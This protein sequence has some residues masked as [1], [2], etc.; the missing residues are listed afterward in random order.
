MPN[1]I[2]LSDQNELIDASKFPYAQFPFDK[3]NPV[4]SRVFE[5]YDKDANALIAA[6]TS[7]GKTVVSEMF[8][9]YEVR[10]RGGKAMYL[11]PLKALTQEKID[12][13]TEECHH[14]S[15]LKL[16]ICTG[17][18]RL[19]PDRKQEL[20]DSD[21]I[22]M[23]TEMLNSVTRNYK[24]EKN[25][26]LS[27]VGT[28]VV[29]ESHLLTV[30]GRG[31]KLEVGLLKLTEINPDVRIVF[32]SAT[33]PNV[34]QIA[35]WLTRIN[36]KETYILESQ[37]RPCP[38]QIHY[39]AYDDSPWKYEAKEREKISVAIDLVTQH[40]QDKFL[41]FAHTKR[42]GDMMVKA[43]KEM[44][45]ESEFHNADLNKEKRKKLEHRFKTDKS[46]R[47][48]VSTS[49]LAWGVNVPAR[50]VI[51]LGVH[52]GMEIV[53]TYDISQMVGRAG[54]PK[55]DPRGDAYV[56]L[57][58]T[59][60]GEHIGRLTKPQPIISQ[61]VGDGSNFKVLAFH[62]ISEINHGSIKTREDIFAWY[63]RTLAAFQNTDLKHDLVDKMV[64][65]LKAC[66]AVKEEKG[67]FTTTPVG[68][69]AALFYFSPFDV[70]DFNR[71]FKAI[72]DN[73]KE[74]DEYWIAMALAN[75][76][77]HRGGIVSAAEKEQITE[78][79]NKIPL[80]VVQ[81]LGTKENFSDAVKKAGYCYYSMMHGI[82]NPVLAGMT[83]GLKMDFNRVT[84]VLH[85]LDAMF[86]WDKKSYLR[87][88]SRRVDYGVEW[89]LLDLC[90]LPGI[91]KV[92][93]TRLWNSNVKTLEDV[94]NKTNIVKIALGLTDAKAKELSE[95]A[96]VFMTQ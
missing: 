94:A 5:I 41:I 7:A 37:Y 4:Q 85:A 87:K 77:S 75:I 13:W 42:T 81:A 60:V 14:F 95:E 31:D 20:A 76:D 21:V 65:S 64:A 10:E 71:N 9:S 43:L 1:L 88:L 47:V 52:R 24:S 82:S 26:F 70:S 12:D 34:K 59:E 96:Q 83:T 48:L 46:F 2:S 78:F 67:S 92:K 73:E 68:R 72:F 39:L 69:V 29:D 18:Y 58:R 23:T 80:K 93:A 19:T 15:D 16:S 90:R 36:G 84:E 38:L 89:D 74:L 62:L 61:M 27:N 35:E 66:G 55:F 33:M 32:L 91:G 17:D 3:L 56:L 6:S 25:Q 44:G 30:P 49:S 53:P 63:D 54:R 86:K 57:P 50:R 22:L 8:S 45:I 11:S 79:A 51:I 40:F 28:V